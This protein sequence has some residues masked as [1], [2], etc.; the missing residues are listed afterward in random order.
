[1][2]EEGVLVGR[3]QRSGFSSR[4][5]PGLSQDGGTVWRGVSS[6]LKVGPWLLTWKSLEAGQLATS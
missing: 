3:P 4:S 1:M 6:E 5:D 2:L